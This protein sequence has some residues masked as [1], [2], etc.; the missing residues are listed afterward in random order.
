MV[1]IKAFRNIP[2][3]VKEGGN[4]VKVLKYVKEKDLDGS[5]LVV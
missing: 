5:G 1:A 2:H 4:E 3:A